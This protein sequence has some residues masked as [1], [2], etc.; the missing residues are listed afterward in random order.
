MAKQY[1]PLND[2]VL[3]I[4]IE[5]ATGL[6]PPDPTEARDQI[7]RGAIY[8]PGKHDDLKR[9][10]IVHWVRFSGSGRTTRIME[11]NIPVQIAQIPY[12]R[13]TMVERE[14]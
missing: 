11:G 7:T 14:G 12:D 13:L 9:S 1:V 6:T 8:D 3:V 4:P 2:Y 10:D 5:E